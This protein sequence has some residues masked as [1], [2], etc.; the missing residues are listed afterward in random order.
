[1][2]CPGGGMLDVP[3]PRTADVAVSARTDPPPVAAGPVQLV[4]AAPGTVAGRPVRHFVPAEPG[5]GEQPVGQLVL[6]GQIIVV[7]RFELAPIDPYGQPGAVFD[8]QCVGTDVV[9]A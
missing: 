8:D 5:V 6:V 4:V 3:P 9:R 7:G 2:A 1:P